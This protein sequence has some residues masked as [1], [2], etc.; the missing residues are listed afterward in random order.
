MSY[1]VVLQSGVLQGCSTVHGLA[2]LAGGAMCGGGCHGC[3][4]AAAGMGTAGHC[5]THDYTLC[6][7]IRIKHSLGRHHEIH[8]IF[9]TLYIHLSHL[10]HFTVFLPFI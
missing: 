7:F 5:T 2:T 1:A 8:L 4:G 3:G 6:Q 9:L 10:V